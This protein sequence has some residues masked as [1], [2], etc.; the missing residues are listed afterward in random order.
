MFLYD[1]PLEEL[2]TYTLPQTKASDFAAF[3]DGMRARSK[4]QPLHPAGEKVPYNVPEVVVEKVSYE[5]FDGGR[6]VGWLVTLADRRPRPTLTFFH[7]YSGNKGPVANYLLWAL[8][9]YTCLAWDVRGQLG[10]STD[11][12]DYPSGR[13]AGW[14][15]SGILE[16]EKYYFARAYIDTIRALDFACTREEV[17]AKRI[18]VTGASQGGGLSLACASLDPRPALCMAE[19]PGF[20]HFARTL[21]LTRAAPWTDLTTYFQRR[22]WD[23]DTAMNTL[24]YVEL[25]NLTDRIQCPT[26]VS[27]G[28]LDELCPPSTVFTAYNRI[29]VGEKRLDAFPYNGHEAGL[30]IET[31]ITWARKHLMKG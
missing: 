12:A 22:P 29:P 28:L 8:Q 30:N 17:D 14:M 1:L 24:S 7:G 16:P 23:I 9:G 26:L 11:F 21:Q 6:I 20:G 10:E 31:M 13:F 25:N 27:A 5:A 15:T 4:A 18:G 19:V 2:R 3:W